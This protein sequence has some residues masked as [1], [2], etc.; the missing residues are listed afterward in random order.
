MLHPEYVS[1]PIGCQIGLSLRSPSLY[2]VLHS[3]P[4]YLTRL[5]L[6]VFRGRL[7]HPYLSAR[8]SRLRTVQMVYPYFSTELF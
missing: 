2:Q 8:T 4:R 5:D 3:N 1:L 7:C 6:L